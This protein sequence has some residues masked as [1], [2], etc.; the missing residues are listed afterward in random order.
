MF[1]VIFTKQAIKD[2]EKCKHAKLGA[3]VQELSEIMQAN[4]FQTPPT[5]EK[6][7]GELQGYYSRRIN[8]Q[9]RF[10]YEVLPIEDKL[11]DSKGEPYEGCVKILRM[12]T[13]YE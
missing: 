4:P 10:I 11:C 9:H 7:V 1:E 3:K 12:W 5:F 8:S 2:L 6:L 13:H